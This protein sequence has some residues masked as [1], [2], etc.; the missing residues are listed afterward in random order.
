MTFSKKN[1]KVIGLR[2]ASFLGAS[3]NIDGSGAENCSCLWF[4]AGNKYADFW[5]EI[6]TPNFAKIQCKNAGKNFALFAIVGNT[7]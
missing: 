3:C 7:G 2:Y 1:K 4:L 6:K 5:R